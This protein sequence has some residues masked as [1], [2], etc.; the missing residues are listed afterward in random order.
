MIDIPTT[1]SIANESLKAVGADVGGACEKQDAI[2]QTHNAFNTYNEA[3]VNGNSDLASSAVKKGHL[4]ST[5]VSAVKTT[6]A[7]QELKAEV[8]RN[9]IPTIDRQNFFDFH[10]GKD[11]DVEKTGVDTGNQK[12][13]DFNKFQSSN[14]LRNYLGHKSAIKRMDRAMK[15]EG[16]SE[17]FDKDTKFGDYIP[18][19]K[20]QQFDVEKQQAAKLYNS[21]L[22]LR[23]LNTLS[24][25]MID[26]TAPAESMK[27]Y[28]AQK[29]MFERNIEPQFT[30][31]YE[32]ILDK[33]PQKKP[34]ISD[35]MK[36]D[37]F[38]NLFGGDSGNDTASQVEKIF[39]N[40]MVPKRQE[41]LSNYGYLTTSIDNYFPT[42]HSNTKI[43]SAGFQQYFE[44]ANR[45][46]DK[47][48]MEIETPEQARQVFQ[49]IYNGFEARARGMDTDGLRD[50]ED[51][52]STF[53]KKKRIVFKDGASAYEYHKKYGITDNPI[54][55]MNKYVNDSAKEVANV[56]LFGESSGFTELN[57]L[58]NDNLG[59]AKAL[60]DLSTTFSSKSTD[61]D[62]VDSLTRSGLISSKEVDALRAEGLT[63]DE[64]LK[65]QIEVGKFPETF[66]KEAKS[67]TKTYNPKT[68]PRILTKDQKMELD[69]LNLYAK[70]GLNRDGQDAGLATE[71]AT[72]LLQIATSVRHLGASLWA[73]GAD[74]ITTLMMHS[75]LGKGVFQG[76]AESLKVYNFSKEEIESL[77]GSFDH[78]RIILENDTEAGRY[79][80][81]R[82]KA[83]SNI[84]K[85]SGIEIISRQTK[86]AQQFSLLSEITRMADRSYEELPKEFQELLDKKQWNIY[87]KTTGGLEHIRGVPI[88]NPQKIMYEDG[89]SSEER[90]AATHING[91]V[92]DLIASAI[93]EGDMLS[94][95]KYARG[96][97]K[98]D[99]PLLRL[100]HKGVFQGASIPLSFA[101]RVYPMMSYLIGNGKYGAV[102]GLAM[103]A[104]FISGTQK[105]L[106]EMLQGKTPNANLFED[107]NFYME[108]MI[109]SGLTMGWTAQTLWEMHNADT[110]GDAASRLIGGGGLQ[111]TYDASKLVSYG[112]SGDSK[113]F[114]KEANNIFG[115]DFSIKNL[116][117]AGLVTQKILYD[118]LA[119][120]LDPEAAQARERRI[121][122]AQK[123]G[124]DYWLKP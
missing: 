44:D 113:K 36:R 58:F 55:I 6:I 30:R 13:Q 110:F 59:R 2:E 40:E 1:F 61:T 117:V 46:F 32:K 116:P 22:K 82:N 69:D 104:M 5:G 102:S 111:T 10:A 62:I 77:I 60:N 54:E 23:D 35:D 3:V 83:S 98:I 21:A 112:L 41:L 19:K 124:Y 18:L 26:S 93:Q 85:A 17:Y 39:H 97:A 49:N 109:N 107:P 57:H 29:P 53:G 47:E 72:G 24:T 51:I 121:K 108:S 43:A 14:E 80:A 71:A 99:N 95:F 87:R 103:Y 91:T 122:S 70:G 79:T 86:A 81:L 114:K 25:K 89:F 27:R 105:I 63:D 31:T 65:Q 123:E 90:E 48:A 101:R 42:M 118:N 67:D 8:W 115:N 45:Y 100:I 119:A 73:L 9:S 33:L 52:A 16:F 34:D 78:Q 75:R 84:M 37:I 94:S 66:L 88:L 28:V 20:M 7:K 64:V 12:I 11:F 74:R 15:S 38:T 76:I 4:F 106:K 68:D 92:N 56:Q 96:V 120:A 50:K